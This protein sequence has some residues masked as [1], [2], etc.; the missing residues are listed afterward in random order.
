MRVMVYDA[1]SQTPQIE[2]ADSWQLGG[3]VYRRLG[4]LDAT[5]GCKT[6]AEAIGWL[7]DFKFVD[8]VQFWGHGSPGR[9]WLGGQ[10]LQPQDLKSLD[11]RRLFWAR[12]C[13]SFAGYPGQRLAWEL[14]QTLGCKVA[15]H[16]HNIGLLHSGLRTL[17]PGRMANWS[18]YEGVKTGTPEAPQQVEWSSPLAPRTITFLHNDIPTGW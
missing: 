7:K 8:E 3:S 17:L 18:S 5:R 9:L 10:S 4:R 2:L 6:W 12:T 13:G 11:V 15:G 16:T 1:S 14:A